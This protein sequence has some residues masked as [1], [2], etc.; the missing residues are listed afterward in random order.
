VIAYRL[1]NFVFDAYPGA[2]AR[3]AILQVRFDGAR[4]TGWEA[5]P[6]VIRGGIPRAAD[7]RSA[8]AIA[9]A[10]EM[11]PA[12]RDELRMLGACARTEGTRRAALHN[13]AHA[14]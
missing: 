3:S 10:L 13:S 2:A 8:R 1:G 14:G 7:A 11:G 5:I 9:R 6:V 4:V 12:C